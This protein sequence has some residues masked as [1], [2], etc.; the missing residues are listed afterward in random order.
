MPMLHLFGKSASLL[1]RHFCHLWKHVSRL[2][3]GQRKCWSYLSRLLWWLPWGLPC[4]KRQNCLWR[5]IPAKNAGWAKYLSQLC[6]SEANRWLAARHSSANEHPHLTKSD[7][8]TS[9]GASVGLQKLCQAVLWTSLQEWRRI[10]LLCILATS[11][12]PNLPHLVQK[13]FGRLLPLLSWKV[14]Q[15]L[16]QWQREHPMPPVRHSSQTCL[17]RAANMRG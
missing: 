3:S 4:H 9:F 7:K 13:R 6:T 17:R 2:E 8:A 1:T 16:N 14:C 15:N 5:T 11:L 10:A 12:M